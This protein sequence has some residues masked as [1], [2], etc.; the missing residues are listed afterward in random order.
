M[1]FKLLEPIKKIFKKER[2]IDAYINIISKINNISELYHHLKEAV[3]ELNEDYEKLLIIVKKKKNEYPVSERIALNVEDYTIDLIKALDELDSSLA[4]YSKN[5]PKSIF[6][7]DIS[8]LYKDF[9]PKAKKFLE[10]IYLSI[11][12][13]DNIN[14]N[15][16]SFNALFKE[17][18]R[19]AK[20]KISEIKAKYAEL[21]ELHSHSF[22]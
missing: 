10:Q 7:A 4:T 16:D 18:S 9:Y 19:K 21:S 6:I 3:E 14:S 2:E 12:N 8:S 11:S 15:F 22:I 17:F 13:I 1:V 20:S 5:Y